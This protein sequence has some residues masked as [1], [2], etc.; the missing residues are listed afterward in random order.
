MFGFC[1]AHAMI[2]NGLD[3]EPYGLIQTYGHGMEPKVFWGINKCQG[4]IRISL[5][6]AA[7]LKEV[8]PPL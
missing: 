5:K 8:S 4:L 2:H 6:G 1:F 3:L 7:R